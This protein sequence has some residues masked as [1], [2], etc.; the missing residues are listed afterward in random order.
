MRVTR[1]T[2]AV[3]HDIATNPGRHWGYN[4]HQRTGIKTGVITP[5]LI[6][7]RNAGWLDAH[8]E[9]PTERA[10]DRPPRR[11]YTLTDTGR[12]EL[13]NLLA[14]AAADARYAHLTSGAPAKTG[15]E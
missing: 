13:A 1:A 8:D 15:G 11:Y 4:I 3:A 9:D 5:I 2:V 12:R 7:M 14:R 6:R 10:P